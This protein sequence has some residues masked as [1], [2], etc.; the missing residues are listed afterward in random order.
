MH[1]KKRVCLFYQPLQLFSI[2]ICILYSV[3]TS[4]LGDLY[5]NVRYIHYL[6]I[7]SSTIRIIIFTHC[8]IYTC[9]FLRSFI[10]NVYF[11]ILLLKSKNRILYYRIGTTV[12]PSLHFPIVY[13]SCC[14]TYKVAFC[15]EIQALQVQQ[16]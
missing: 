1:L 2:M 7:K 4:C 16:Y 12:S 11:T 13:I 3:I 9:I 8:A 5:N 10:S 15:N 14:V 6:L